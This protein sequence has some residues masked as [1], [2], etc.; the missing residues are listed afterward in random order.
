MTVRPK[1]QDFT[2]SKPR[3]AV[4][5]AAGEVFEL[6]LSL[7][8][9]G[10]GPDHG[11]DDYEIDGAW[12][13]EMRAKLPGDVLALIQGLSDCCFVWLPLVG[14]A[15]ALGPPYTI[16]RFLTYLEDADPVVLRRR[17]LSVASESNAPIDE[18]VLEAAAAGDPDALARLP[19]WCTE[20]TALLSLLEP[21]P[22]E[23]RRMIIDVVRR[24][25]DASPFGPE[26]V[27]VLERDAEHK[28]SLARRMDPERLVETATNGIT[29]TPQPDLAGVIL[30]PSVVARP[31]VIITERGDQRIFCYSVA[32]EHLSA[33][34]DAPPS[35]LVQFYKALG[36]ER[37]L[38]ILGHLAEG[39]ASL[40]D[41]VA[42]LGLAKSTVH[43]HVRQLRTA[44]LVRVTVGDEKEYSLRTDAVP[45][46]TRLLEGFLGLGA[47]AISGG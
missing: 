37:R 40:G 12:F 8:V 20:C 4:Q 42:R 13:D 5:V 46:A 33:D 28:R 29:V 35:W 14:D 41:L 23:T 18:A 45:E 17:I 31:W 30:I 16:D 7:F 3:L 10:A 39:P 32:D 2:A 22:T 19:E 26:T 47:M 1:V 6:L 34:P 27:A 36:D 25:R 44:G 15:H 43:H 9:L 24:F 38:Q 21:S 11:G